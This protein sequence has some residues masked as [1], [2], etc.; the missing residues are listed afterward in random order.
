MADEKTRMR[1]S[2]TD[3]TIEKLTALAGGE[4]QRSEWL[5]TVVQ[6]MAAGYQLVEPGATQELAAE[7]ASM[8]NRLAMMEAT[9]RRVLEKLERER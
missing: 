1:L 4:R 5:E 6:Q 9:L 2:V 8:N 3:E 7:L